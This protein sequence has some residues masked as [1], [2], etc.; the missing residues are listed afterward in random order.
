MMPSAAA[1]SGWEESTRIL[2][3]SRRP[4]ALT[5]LRGWVQ[6]IPWQKRVPIRAHRNENYSMSTSQN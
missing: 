1:I 5:S 2:Y 6:I 3:S 4:P